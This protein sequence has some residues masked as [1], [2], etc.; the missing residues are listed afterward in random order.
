[1]MARGARRRESGG[2]ASLQHLLEGVMGNLDL[3]ARLKEQQARQAWARVAGRVVGAHAQVEAMRDGVLIVA[4]D[5]PAWAQELHMR[6]AELLRRLQPL[7][8]EGVVREIRFRS[9]RRRS[10]SEEAPAD[11]RPVVRKLSER[12]LREARRAS[13]V[14]E[15]PELREKAERAFCSLLKIAAWRKE[16]GWQCCSRCGRWQKTGKRW[17]ASCLHRGRAEA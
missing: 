1:M 11:D 17:C 6:Q 8:G 16:Q 10:A 2:S 14:I 4:T 5:S 3:G 12:Q 7:V 9:G 13:A 15:D